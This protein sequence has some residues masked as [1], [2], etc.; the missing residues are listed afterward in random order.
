MVN[1]IFNED[2]LETMARMESD[3]LDLILTSPPYDA[4]RKYGGEKTYHQRLND[5]GYS[6]PFEDIALEMIRVLKP[7]GVIM[8]N[9]ADQ[10]I[11][12]S[13]T[14]NSMRQALFFMENG[15]LL[16]DHLIWYKTGTPFPS[17]YRYRNVWENMFVFSKGKPTTFNP[18]LKKNKSGGDTRLS[19]RYRNHQGELVEKQKVVTT[20]EYGID[21]NVWKLTNAY[22]NS[23]EWKDANSHPAIMPDELAKRHIT[24]WTNEGGIVYD[25]FLGSGTTT[26]IAKQLNRLWIG[27]EL[28]TPYY[29]TANKIMYGKESNRTQEE[30]SQA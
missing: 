9:V 19:R 20:K 10:T 30:S 2:C 13:R 8:W 22:F 7:G 24:S 21:D 25:P 1:Q 3:Y 12:G 5:T 29:E 6:F 18:I 28:H 23:K 11:K 26:R 15:L 17:P 27:S 16:H 14:G 4:M